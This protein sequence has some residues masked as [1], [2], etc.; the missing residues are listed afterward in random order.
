MNPSKNNISKQYFYTNNGL[1]HRC[2]TLQFI[3][4]I[5]W[6]SFTACCCLAALMSLLFTMS[7]VYIMTVKLYLHSPMVSL[8]HNWLTFA[9]LLLHSES[10]E[11]LCCLDCF[12][13]LLSEYPQW[14]K[15][16]TGRQHLQS[17]HYLFSMV[18]ITVLI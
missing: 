18:Q 14:G 15:E 6:F 11:R 16:D 8:L 9:F 2:T 5:L 17:P 4:C 10:P 7:C 1:D 12:I 13:S 3:L